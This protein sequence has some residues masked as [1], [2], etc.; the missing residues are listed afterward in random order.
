[1]PLV[2]QPLCIFYW[3]DCNNIQLRKIRGGSRI[4]S[5]G[6]SGGTMFH[7][8]AVDISGEGTEGG[9]GASPNKILNMKCARSDY[10]HTWPSQTSGTIFSRAILLGTLLQICENIVFRDYSIRCCVNVWTF[11][12]DF[13]Q[14]NFF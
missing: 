14:C 7:R 6:G 1:M 10:E 8:D 13:C 4:F 11:W 12:V 5:Q 2:I 3:F 9:W